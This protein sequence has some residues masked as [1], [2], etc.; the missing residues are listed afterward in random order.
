[1]ISESHIYKD[2]LLKFAADLKKRL[3]KMRWT[4]RSILI[5]EKELFYGFFI[6]RKLCETLKIS[7]SLKI[8]CYPVCVHDINAP[9]DINFT[10]DH[11]ILEHIDFENQ[12]IEYMKITEICNQFIHSFLLRICSDEKGGLHSILVS[13]DWF[14]SRKCLMI[15]INTV[16]KIF[17]E[18]GK[19]YPHEIHWTRESETLKL[20]KCIVK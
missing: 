19:N 20:I 18:I 12:S 4:E 3:I 8:K 15:E 10:T 1:M 5:V 9:F 2:E 6:I 16:I 14:K 13:S 11:K 17:K 7:D